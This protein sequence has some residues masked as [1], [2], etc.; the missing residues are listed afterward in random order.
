MKQVPRDASSVTMAY[1]TSETGWVELESE[2]SVVSERGMLTANVN[3][4][5]AFAV[6]AT[7]PTP[8]IEIIKRYLW[9]VL[10]LLLLLVI[11]IYWLLKKYVFSD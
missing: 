5:T 4:F 11:I 1:Y 7:E 10:I 3:H 2:N 6:L 9:L 8:I